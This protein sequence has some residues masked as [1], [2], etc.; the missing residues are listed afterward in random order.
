MSD[1]ALQVKLYEDF[2]K[3]QAKK[4]VDDSVQDDAVPDADVKKPQGAIHIFQGVFLRRVH[5]RCVS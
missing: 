3:S 5:S 4:T 2:S 1:A